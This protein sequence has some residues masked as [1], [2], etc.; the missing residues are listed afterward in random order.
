MPAN[1]LVELG[2]DDG[3]VAVTAIRAFTAAA[4]EL[5][6][7]GGAYVESWPDQRALLGSVAYLRSMGE[8]W[9][10]RHP[11]LRAAASFPASAVVALPLTACGSLP[12]HRRE[13]R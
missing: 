13:S 9:E 1:A 8:C 11:L 2:E 6:R 3:A 10:G 7:A 5:A 4:I 12:L